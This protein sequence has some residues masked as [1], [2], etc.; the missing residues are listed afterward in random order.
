MKERAAKARVREL[1]VEPSKRPAQEDLQR[2]IAEAAYYRAES[3]GSQ[4][5][6][7]EQD[8]RAAE[9]EVLARVRGGAGLR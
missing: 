7:E 4:L 5:G 9:A 3:R 1:P 8:W 2:L 6:S